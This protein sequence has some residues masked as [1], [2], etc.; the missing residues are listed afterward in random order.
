VPGRSLGIEYVGP[1]RN[2]KR[3]MP[4][5]LYF[6]GEKSVEEPWNLGLERELQKSRC[7]GKSPSGFIY[8][9]A[10][11]HPSAWPT[12]A[13]DFGKWLKTGREE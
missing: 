12:A 13:A 4:F 9:E 11:D 6:T 8:L 3:V 2:E 5:R 10:A 1:R 7:L